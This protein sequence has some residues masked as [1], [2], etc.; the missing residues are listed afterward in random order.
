[1]YGYR[2]HPSIGAAPARR[3]RSDRLLDPRRDDPR[4]VA[5]ASATRSAASSAPHSPAHTAQRPSPELGA[6]DTLLAPAR[7]RHA[8]RPPSAAPGLPARL[9][10]LR[11]REGRRGRSVRAA[12]RAAPAAGRG[13]SPARQ[14]S[15]GSTA[16]TTVPPPAGLS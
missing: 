7:E 12:L 9:P 13:V 3:R 1:M 11:H 6:R 16:L 8:L 2:I 15:T 10:D 5:P 14:S 4:R